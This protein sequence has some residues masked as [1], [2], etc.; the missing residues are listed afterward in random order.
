LSLRTKFTLP[1]HITVFCL[2]F[3]L[4][5]CATVIQAPPNLHTSTNAKVRNQ[6]L[7]NLQDFEAIG[8]IGFSD[9]QQ[10]GNASI[11]WEQHPQSYRVRLYGPLG[12][13]AVQIKGD[14]NDVSLTKTDG[15]IITA[16]T[17]EAL[18]SKELG[19]V[20]PVSG[21]RYWLRGLP[22]PGTAP[23]KMLLDDSNR[24]WQM[25]QQDWNIQ[26]QAYKS[27]DGRD[28]PYKLL[29]TNGSI[30][31]KFIFDRWSLRE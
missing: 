10:G 16:N 22:A 26:Y 15:K 5:G 18:V 4:N 13:G 17:P 23:K 14:S 1:L 2:A 27:I 30:R 29:L 21:L 9:G 19:W 11:V 12:S 25:N 6:N 8:K 31:L 7:A 24:L 28:V 20:I 3:L